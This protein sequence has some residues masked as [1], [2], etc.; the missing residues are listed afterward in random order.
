MLSLFNYVELGLLHLL[1]PWMVYFQLSIPLLSGS[2]VLLI[3]WLSW[4]I[5][6]QVTS[7]FFI[8]NILFNVFEW[9]TSN[10]FYSTLSTSPQLFF[11]ITALLR[12]YSHHK[13]CPFK[14]CNSPP[15]LLLTKVYNNYRRTLIKW[16]MDEWLGQP[17]FHTLN[18]V[19]D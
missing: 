3:S 6:W 4:C 19:L 15:P 5:L 16:L 1:P 8:F 18:S 14:M 12:Y 9:L 10:I 13:I 2:P 11:F 17:Q 7:I